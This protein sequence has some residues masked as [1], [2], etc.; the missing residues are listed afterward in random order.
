MSSHSKRRGAGTY[1]IAIIVWSFVVVG[2]Y[3]FLRTEATEPD[4]KSESSK[5]T[6]GK[7]TEKNGKDNTGA[8]EDVPRV[9]G[10]L[11]EINP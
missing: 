8:T 9:V 2:V 6:S 5:G 10:G 4:D 11:L 1:L 3:L 7:T